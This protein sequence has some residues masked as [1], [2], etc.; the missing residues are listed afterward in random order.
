MEEPVIGNPQHLVHYEDPDFKMRD[1]SI[2]AF[3]DSLKKNLAVAD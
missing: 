2:L 1:I 3:Q